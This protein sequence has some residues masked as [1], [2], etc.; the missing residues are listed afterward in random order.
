MRTAKNILFPI[1]RSDYSDVEL[2]GYFSEWRVFEENHLRGLRGRSASSSGENQMMPNES[3]LAISGG[4]AESASSGGD[5][6]YSLWGSTDTDRGQVST[7]NSVDPD[8][9][10]GSSVTSLRSTRD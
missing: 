4:F 9:D 8:H 5:A 6:D 10:G 2:A 1:G 3:G 7:P